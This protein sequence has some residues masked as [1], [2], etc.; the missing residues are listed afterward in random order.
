MKIQLKFFASF[1]ANLPEGSQG[2]LATVDI[3]EGM[4]VHEV[5]DRYRIPR[6]LAQIV[7]VNGVFVTVPDRDQR[8]FNEGDTLAVWPAVAGG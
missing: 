5:L 3:P 1:T 8:C 2:N 7:L 6:D 4:T